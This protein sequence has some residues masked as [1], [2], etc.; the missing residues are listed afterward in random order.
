MARK[1]V[2][3][4][5]AA[6]PS[7]FLS[8]MS[9]WVQQGVESFLATQRILVDMGMQ[10]NSNA[11]KT[12]R[13]GLTDP[14][15]SPKAILTEVAVEGTSNFIE[16][17]RILLNL[18]QQEGEI[19]MNG[20]KERMGS[21]ARAMAM[22][23]LLRRSLDTFVDMQQ[24]FLTIASKH[25]QNWLQP[26]KGGNGDGNQ[27]VNLARE[28]ME[29]FIR[30]QKKFLE[31]VAE[32]AQKA[33]S[34]KQEP[35]AKKM[36]KTEVSKLA[37]E[38]ANSFIEAQKK[39]LDVAGQQMNVNQQA[40]TKAKDMIAPFQL[41]PLADLTNKGVKTFVDAE[42]ALID[43]IRDRR[44]AAKVA[45]KPERKARRPRKTQEAQV[46]HATA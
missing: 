19:V 32:E 45:E 38:A 33:V 4:P 18:V 39:L 37:R 29:N 1:E 2:K 27:L 11:I 14:E 40:V 22:T 17:H 34:G 25:S 21:Y 23:D 7:S 15:H 41:L 44:G 13:E 10:K 31:V 5:S 9:G 12:V 24:E 43:S 36:V 6:Q 26:V 30:A 35:G 42:K 16:A 8:L 28:G 46:S 3:G 20:M